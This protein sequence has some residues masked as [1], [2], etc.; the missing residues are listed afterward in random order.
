MRDGK[1][2]SAA[3]DIAIWDEDQPWA[4]SLEWAGDA[5]EWAI[6]AEAAKIAGLRTLSFEKPHLEL[7]YA[8]QELEAGLI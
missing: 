3:V 1:P 7:P 5:R 4:K 8:L 2:C 6:V